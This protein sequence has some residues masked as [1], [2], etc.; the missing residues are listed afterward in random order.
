M[1][2]E[3]NKAHNPI[4]KEENK[5]LIIEPTLFFPKFNILNK[6]SSYF[7]KKPI[8][9][10]ELNNTPLDIW[11]ENKTQNKSHI[12]ISDSLQSFNIFYLLSLFSFI[13]LFLGYYIQNIVID[14]YQINYQAI[15]VKSILP[16][17]FAWL[18]YPFI[19]HLLNLK[20]REY[21][22]SQNQHIE[23]N[24]IFLPQKHPQHIYLLNI[25]L[26]IFYIFLFS[27][28]IPFHLGI[29]FGIALCILPLF[30]S[31]SLQTMHIFNGLWKINIFY[32]IFLFSLN[33]VFT[34]FSNYLPYQILFSI[35]IALFSGSLSITF[36][37]RNL[38]LFK[39]RTNQ[40]NSYIWSIICFLNLSDNFIYPSKTN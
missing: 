26:W 29:G 2:K 15:G 23:S 37:I 35:L 12:L 1:V 40:N 13:F 4:I 32:F 20:L 16:W 19:N 33:M 9:I 18:T 17:T 25:S 3:K 27:L 5:P 34:K 8:E 39:C 38:L 6:I 30:L 31:F 14:T 21:I 24:Y 10:I 28:F 7:S 11:C 22:T 36:F